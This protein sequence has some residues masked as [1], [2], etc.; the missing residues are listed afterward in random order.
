MENA[1]QKKQT[2]KNKHWTIESNAFK[3]N[4]I[5]L[6]WNYECQFFLRRKEKQK[7]IQLI[8]RNTIH[9][10]ENPHEKLLKTECI[11]THKSTHAELLTPV[12]VELAAIESEK[13]RTK[14]AKR[15]PDNIKS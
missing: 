15:G 1:T 3:I 9:L 7:W 13:N 5:I 8:E 11:I 6:R 12:A 14:W 4:I 2:N 10:H